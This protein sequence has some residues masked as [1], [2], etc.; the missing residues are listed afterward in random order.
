MNELLWNQLIVFSLLIQFFTRIF[1]T[2]C[3]ITCPIGKSITISFRHLRAAVRREL[4]D[5]SS[6]EGELPEDVLR[7]ERRAHRPSAAHAFGA[8]ADG[9]ARAQQRRQ[10]LGQHALSSVP[11]QQD[12]D[13]GWRW[14]CGRRPKQRTT[15]FPTRYSMISLEKVIAYSTVFSASQRNNLKTVLLL[16]TNCWCGC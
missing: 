1:S 2:R 10:T 6:G 12:V 7:A 16:Q 5:R 13:V 14:S 8:A 15:A 3:K 11:R 9:E 4:V